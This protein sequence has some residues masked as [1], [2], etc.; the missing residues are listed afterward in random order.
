MCFI[1]T[2]FHFLDVCGNFLENRF[3]YKKSYLYICM[4]DQTSDRFSAPVGAKKLYF[5]LGVYASS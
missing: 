1:Y 4:P 2:F 5:D 3:H